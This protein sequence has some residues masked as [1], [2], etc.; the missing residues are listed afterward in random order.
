M[1]IRSSDV[2]FDEGPLLWQLA[3]NND[4]DISTIEY[5]EDD[6]NEH[7][8]PGEPAS[9]KYHQSPLEEPPEV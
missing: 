2:I 4:E 6:D 9:S 1:V 5:P 8:F 3:G 7:E